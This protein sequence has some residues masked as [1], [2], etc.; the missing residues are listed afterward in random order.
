MATSPIPHSDQPDFLNTVLIGGSLTGPEVLLSIAKKLE[1][2]TG[3]RLGARDS[4]RVLDIDLLL[5]GDLV[6]RTPE[7]TI[8][9]PRL[10]TRRFVLA[11]LVAIAPT[12]RIPPDGRTARSLL[13]DLS[14]DQRVDA[15]QW[16]TPPL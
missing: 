1:W 12:L 5:W 14:D 15:L 13:A 6:L 7:L 4:A 2:E 3:R 10:R 11:P 9:H 16:S 8:P